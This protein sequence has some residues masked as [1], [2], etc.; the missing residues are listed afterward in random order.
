MPLNL[1]HRAAMIEDVKPRRLLP[2]LFA[3]A[4]ALLAAW[5]LAG[6]GDADPQPVKATVTPTAKPAG[7]STYRAKEWG[8]SLRYDAAAY[9]LQADELTSTLT[10][11]PSLFTGKPLQLEGLPSLSVSL[12]ATPAG[13]TASTPTV[14]VVAERLPFS[15]ADMGDGLSAWLRDD[16]LEEGT[17]AWKDVLTDEPRQTE[18]GGPAM[19]WT[20]EAVGLDETAGTELHL[21]AYVVAYGDYVYTLRTSATRKDWEDVAPKLAA[22]VDTFTIDPATAD[23]GPAPV[24]R[25]YSDDEY[26]FSMEVPEGL[27]KAEVA[28]DPT[29][30]LQFGVQ[31][32]DVHTTPSIALSVGVSSTPEGVGSSQSGLLEKFYRNAAE[33]LREMDGVVSVSAPTQVDLGDETAWMI[34]VTRELSDGR[35]LR[36]RIYDVWQSA[37]VYSVS[38]R[39][40][41]DHWD[42]DWRLLEPAVSSFNAD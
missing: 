20:F 14:S 37:Y 30:D 29:A 13:D 33:S 31:F 27:A 41:A 32:V 26:G 11:G 36:T 40:R 28:D 24:E 23:T 35:L 21:R 9:E 10:L 16:L 7:L 6:C 5:L 8:F 22:I 18:L 17:T 34:D 42:E 38:A 25:A 12:L 1:L 2:V 4:V 39:G 19:A 15:V 3:L